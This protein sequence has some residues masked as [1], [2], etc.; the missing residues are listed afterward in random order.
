[1][2]NTNLRKAAVLLLS[3]PYQERSQLL[4]RLEPRQSAAV[5]AAMNGLGEV[6]VAEREAVLGEFVAA[7]PVTPSRR[8]PEKT[9]PFRFL[10]DLETD[11]LLDLI[12]DEQPQ[13]VALI[14][15]CVPPQQAAAVLGSLMIEDQ[16]AL[17]CRMATAGAASPEVVS[18]VESALRRRLDAP[19]S[20]PANT[21]GVARIVRILNMMSPAAERRLLASLSQTA[22]QLVGELRQAMFGADAATC[23]EPDVR[24]AAG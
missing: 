18:D 20:S 13:T 24:S 9:V 4:G 19:G 6:G 7:N 23:D 11:A 17:V 2:S 3:L 22:P 10:H 21:R 15:S 14:L 12:A 16:T 1:M 8:R 5:A